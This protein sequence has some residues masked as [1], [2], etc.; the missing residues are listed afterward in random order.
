MKLSKYFLCEP[1]NEKNI[2]TRT[3]YF[4]A[5]LQ[6][7]CVTRDRVILKFE[8]RVQILRGSFEVW[9]RDSEFLWERR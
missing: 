2:A 3:P 5:N 6:S 4:S 8:A 1:L 9:L 7:I